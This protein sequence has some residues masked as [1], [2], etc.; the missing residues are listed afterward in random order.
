MQAM[1]IEEMAAS[2]ARRALEN[3]EFADFAPF[4]Q[5]AAQRGDRV[6]ELTTQATELTAL[7]MARAQANKAGLDLEFGRPLAEGA[8]AEQQAE[9][10]RRNTANRQLQEVILSSQSGRYLTPLGV[11]ANGQFVT[12]DD[13]MG[14]RQVIPAQQW[15]DSMNLIAQGM[16]GGQQGGVDPQQG[17][18]APD[19]TGLGDLYPNGGTNQQTPA[20]VAAPVASPAQAQPVRNM[21]TAAAL[22]QSFPGIAQPSASA[23]PPAAPQFNPIVQPLANTPATSGTPMAPPVDPQQT[24]AAMRWYQD[25]FG[26]ALT[27]KRRGTAP[28]ESDVRMAIAS[29][30]KAQND[31]ILRAAINEEM[32]ALPQYAPPQ[33]AQAANQRAMQKAIA[34]GYMP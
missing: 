8:V 25:E 13:G 16:M 27:G 9:I 21:Q 28:R 17:G 29:M 11:S 12:I 18:G 15:Q 1:T 32:A 14:G 23:A 6:G 34:A 5:R 4:R 24:A 7:P 33:M 30:Q 19:P 2:N 26:Q 20:P 22:A 31:E 3:R 10:A